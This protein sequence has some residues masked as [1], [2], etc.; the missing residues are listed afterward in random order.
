MG[1]LDQINA[2]Q[3]V[4]YGNPV[5]TGNVANQFTPGKPKSGG[6]GGLAGILSTVG[7][8]LA[9]GPFIGQAH[10]RQA[11]AARQD[12]MQAQM[13]QAQLAAMTAKQNRNQILQGPN[14]AVFSVDP[15]TNAFTQLHAPEAPITQDPPAVQIARAA[16]LQPGTQEWMRALTAAIPGYGNT[17]PVLQQKNALTLGQIGA[18][19]AGSL[20]VKRTP[21]A[22]AGGGS[23]GVMKAAATRVVGGKAYYKVGGAWYDNPEGK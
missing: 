5:D 3:Q 15:D 2:G 19:T 4:G 12:D 13:Q 23:G 14:G 16:G 17:E 20:A 22:R 18:R 10:A 6:L 21:G 11:R 9:Y 1:L 7:D 8:L